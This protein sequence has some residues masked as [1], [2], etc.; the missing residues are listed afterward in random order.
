MIVPCLNLCQYPSAKGVADGAVHLLLQSGVYHRGRLL[1]LQLRRDD[2]RGEQL[3]LEQGSS[4]IRLRLSQ[5]GT[6]G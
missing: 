1:R 5:L 3:P 6:P 4:S 2:R